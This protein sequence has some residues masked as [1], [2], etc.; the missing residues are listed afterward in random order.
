VRRPSR[1]SL[2]ERQT[3]IGL[4]SGSAWSGSFPRGKIVRSDLNCHRSSPLLMQSL[5]RLHCWLRLQ[6]ATSRPLKQLTSANWSIAICDP[7][8]S[9]SLGNGSR[10]LRRG[11]IMKSSLHHRLDRVEQRKRAAAISTP[12]D[13]LTGL[14]KWRGS[15]RAINSLVDERLGPGGVDCKI[16]TSD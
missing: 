10:G 6:S 11:R 3:E 13:P 9:R 14:R 2:S 5:L 12:L 15:G 4:R 7:M 16:L 8:R 1:R